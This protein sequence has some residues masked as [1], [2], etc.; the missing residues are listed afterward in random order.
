MN[1]TIQG[2]GTSLWGNSK[3]KFVVTDIKFKDQNYVN[4]QVHR[5]YGNLTLSGPNTKWFQYTDKAIEKTLV[6]PEVLR[7]VKKIM[8]ETLGYNPVK[9]KIHWS[10]QGMQPDK[11]WNFDVSWNV[12]SC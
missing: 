10:E 1:L 11:G 9:V 3:G 2:N 5:A 6:N 4:S 8:M 7:L 12:K